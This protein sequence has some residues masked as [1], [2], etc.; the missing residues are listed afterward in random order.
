MA[1]VISSASPAWA[2]GPR[3]RPPFRGL[4]PAG[5]RSQRAARFAEGFW[6]PRVF[7]RR[8]DPDRRRHR[9]GGPRRDGRVLG[10]TLGH[11]AG[12]QPRGRRRRR[13]RGRPR[14]GSAHR[15]CDVRS[16]RNRRHDDPAR[17]QQQPPD[18]P[19]AQPRGHGD[20]LRRRPVALGHLADL[21]RG[22]L[23]PEQ[24]A[25]LRLRGRPVARRQPRADRR[26]GALRARGAG[27]RSPGS[28]LP[29]GGR[30]RSARLHVPV[31]AEQAA[32]RA[33]QLARGRQ[34]GRD[35]GLR[36]DH[37]PL[38]RPDAGHGPGRPLDRRAERQPGRQRH[39][40]ARAGDRGGRDARS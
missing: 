40:G 19:P 14:A 1:K 33:R 7:D 25:R 27:V 11:L 3:S 34:P 32:A 9:A 23:D 5:G 2:R 22:R 26:D 21:R 16:G 8:R 29:D 20:Q 31:S 36:R 6:L 13:R 38:D 4:R 28:R 18:H 37:R 30:R 12:T 24:A 15:G 39:A 10:R 17:R 35:G